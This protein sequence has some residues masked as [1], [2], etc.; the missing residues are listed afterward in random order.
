M[1]DLHVRVLALSWCRSPITFTSFMFL[2]QWI[3]RA[4][5]CSSSQGVG[6]EDKKAFPP[7]SPQPHQHQGGQAHRGC[8]LWSLQLSDTTQDIT[9]S[10]DPDSYYGRKMSLISASVMKITELMIKDSFFCCQYFLILKDARLK[11]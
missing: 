5:C 6:E 1:K 3:R 2:L 4:W 10:D 7:Y 9:A 8:S 11:V